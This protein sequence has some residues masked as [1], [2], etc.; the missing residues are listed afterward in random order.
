MTFLRPLTGPARR[1]HLYND[2][3]RKKMR[4]T[5]TVKAIDKYAD[6]N[7][8]IIRQ[9]LKIQE[10]PTGRFI[11]RPEITSEKMVQ[12]VLNIGRSLNDLILGKLKCV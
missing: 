6:S 1:D 9:E 4:Q 12:T 5:N 8:E 7:E 11:I 2:I 10:F 3:I